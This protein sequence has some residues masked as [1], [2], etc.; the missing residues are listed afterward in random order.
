[1]MKCSVNYIAGIIF[2]VLISLAGAQENDFPLLTGPYIGQKPPGLKPEIFAPGIVSVDKYSEF[3][4]VFTPDG[5][6]CIFDRHGDDEY[7]RGAVFRTRIENG[8]WTEPAIHEGFAKFGEVFLP[9]MSP[10]GQYRFFTSKTLPAPEGIKKIIPMYFIKK[11]EAG[12]SDPQY[13]TQSIHASATLDNIVYVNSGRKIEQHQTFAEIVDLYRLFPF[14]A[15]HSC[16]SPDGTYLIFDN[17]EL[18]RIGQCRLFVIFKKRDGSWT[19]PISLS[20][21]IQQHAFCAWIT[22]DGQ[23]I[24]FHSQDDEKGNIYWVSADIIQQVKTDDD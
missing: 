18:P 4:C 22:C 17:G 7:K 5:Q 11:T 15:G 10:D 23:Y 21:Y 3:V 9:T 24:F 2:F 12:W 16:I 6:E 1:M 19:D 20:K 13:L 14:N 8:R